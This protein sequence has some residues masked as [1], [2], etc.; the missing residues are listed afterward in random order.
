MFAT[1]SPDNSAKIKRQERDGNYDQIVFIGRYANFHGD[2][3]RA[4]GLRITHE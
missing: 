3:F 2:F 1:R 4:V